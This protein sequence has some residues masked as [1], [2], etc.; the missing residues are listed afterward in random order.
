MNIY[1]LHD[2]PSKLDRYSK[3]HMVVPALVWEHGLETGEWNEDVISKYPQFAQ[4]YA[5]DIIKKRFPK[6]EA[7]IATDANCSFKYAK[8]ALKGP[9]KLGEPAIAKSPTF[10]VQYAMYILED[11][12]PEGEAAIA[13]DAFWSETYAM[14]II[15]G[16][17]KMGE[18]AIAADRRIAKRYNA[19]FECDI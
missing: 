16:R 19:F 13:K 3:R 15:K 5:V 18:S 12:F 4:D 14:H 2:A 10:S 1:D 6:G 9:F 8:F 7:A 17:F 11:R